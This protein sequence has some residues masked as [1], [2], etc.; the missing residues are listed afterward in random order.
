MLE[1]YQKRHGGRPCPYVELA[2]TDTLPAELVQWSMGDHIKPLAGLAVQELLRELPSAMR[3]ETLLVA[4][5]AL[6]DE[7]VM[8]ALGLID[9]K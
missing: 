1:Q 9:E 7:R 5:S 3:Y 2:A 8:K 4:R 6:S